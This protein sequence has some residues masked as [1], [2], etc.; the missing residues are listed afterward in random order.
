[1]E[2]MRFFCSVSSAAARVM[3][4]LLCALLVS[5]AWTEPDTSAMFTPNEPALLLPQV[6]GPADVVV[7]DINNDGYNDVVSVAG[8]QTGNPTPGYALHLWDQARGELVGAWFRPTGSSPTDVAVASLNGDRIPDVI[9]T[10]YNGSQLSI[11]L[12]SRGGVPSEQY[13]VP[14]QSGPFKVDVRDIDG[15]GDTEVVCLSRFNV[16]DSGYTIYE[17][18]NT[19]PPYLVETASLTES[20]YWRDIAFADLDGDGTASDLLVLVRGTTGP[21]LVHH[22]LATGGQEEIPL[23]ETGIGTAIVVGDLNHDS[24]DE[25]VI[26]LLNSSLEPVPGTAVLMTSDGANL[27]KSATFTTGTMPASATLKDINDDGYADLLIANTGAGVAGTDG[28]I[29]PDG[30]T[31]TVT[32]ALSKGDG[33]FFTPYE[34]EV[35]D[36]VPSAVGVG[37]LTGNGRA[38]LIVAQSSEDIL[39]VYYNQFPSRT[40][41]PLD[42]VRDG[43]VDPV[44]LFRFA[45]QWGTSGRTGGDLDSSGFV[46]ADDMVRWSDI[47]QSQKELTAD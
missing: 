1:M 34:L 6:L 2:T 42:L 9:A 46:E 22:D 15:D 13:F 30:V 24:I 18:D 43:K 11:L 40:E 4:F 10:A 20:A 7:V 5:P 28:R 39:H 21:Y 29:A 16:F 41:L 3:P 33:T 47:W 17:V 36:I 32:I 45:S 8:R 26:T 37:D 12:G 25:T 23:D 31:D 44:D 27:V 35:G 19:Q 14:T 38:D